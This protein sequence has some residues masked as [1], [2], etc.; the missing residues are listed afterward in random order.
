MFTVEDAKRVQADLGLQD[1]HVAWFDLDEGFVLAHTDAER[2]LQALS[3]LA[4]CDIH[5]WLAAPG[6][7]VTICCFPEAGWYK[8]YGVHK[9]LG[10]PL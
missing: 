6:R 4:E 9:A 1:V 8:V 10:L 2:A 3:P 5:W 7:R